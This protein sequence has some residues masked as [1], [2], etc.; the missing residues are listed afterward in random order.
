MPLPEPIAGA[1]I[2]Q[3]QPWS[4]GREIHSTATG[5]EE[6]EK[7]SPPNQLLLPQRVMDAGKTRL[8]GVCLHL[9]GMGGDR[10]TPD[11]LSERD[12]AFCLLMLCAP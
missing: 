1:V 3:G 8:A 11:G 10:A 6:W 7:G 2:V 5:R 9:L 4:H 12:E